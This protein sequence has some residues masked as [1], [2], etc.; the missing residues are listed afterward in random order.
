MNLRK[1]IRIGSRRSQLAL[2]QVEEV[3]TL[4]RARGVRFDFKRVAF[5]TSGDKDKKTSLMAGVADDFFT[6]TIDRALLKNKIDVAVHS[7]KDLPQNLHPED[8]KSTR[9]NSS[10]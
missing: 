1:T 3:L 9:L 10:H 8:R 4:L 6:D 2:I 5:E 7:A